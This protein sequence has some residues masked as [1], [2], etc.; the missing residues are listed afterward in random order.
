MLHSKECL[1]I[2][3]FKCKKNKSKLKLKFLNGYCKA[4][5]YEKFSRPGQLLLQ[6]VII[7]CKTKGEIDSTIKSG[8]DQNFVLIDA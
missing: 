7:F 2:E 6:I 3:F 5:G 1:A 4:S 8:T